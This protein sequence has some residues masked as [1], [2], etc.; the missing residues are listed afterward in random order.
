MVILLALFRGFGWLVCG[1]LV[2]CTLCSMVINEFYPGGMKQLLK[3]IESEV[4][5]ELKAA[6]MSR[7]ERA[8][9]RKFW[10]D[11]N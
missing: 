6:R 5:A 1:V 3:E 9:R 11:R 7:R 4:W 2:A 10:R 8:R